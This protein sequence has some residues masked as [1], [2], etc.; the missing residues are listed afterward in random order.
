MSQRLP[1]GVSRPRP[2]WCRSDFLISSLANTFRQGRDFPD[3]SDVLA[4]VLRPLD[5]SEPKLILDLTARPRF[6]FY[7]S[8]DRNISICLLLFGFA[9]CEGIIVLQTSTRRRSVRA[10]TRDLTFPPKWRALS[11]STRCNVSCVLVSARRR[12]CP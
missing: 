10:S 3:Q 5:L 4:S 2:A 8:A 11:L 6:L 12:A 9:L 7:K 1:M